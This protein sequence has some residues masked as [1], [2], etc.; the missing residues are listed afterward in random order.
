[1]GIKRHKPEK[2]VTKLREVEV[3]FGQGMPSVDAIRQVHIT[4]QGAGRL[5]RTSLR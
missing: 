2:I 5:I 1:M 3:L 4:D